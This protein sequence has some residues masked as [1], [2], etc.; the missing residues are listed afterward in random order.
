M[1]QRKLIRQLIVI[2]ATLAVPIIP[3]VI[4]GEMPGERWLSAVDDNSLLFGFSGSGLLMLDILLPIPSSIIGT[5]LGARLGLWSGF[6]FTWGGLLVGNFI[7]FSIARFASARFRSW[8]PPFPKSTTQAIVFLSR[9]VPVLAEAVAL[10]AGTTSMPLGRFLL[11]CAGGNAIY[12]GALCGNGATL[13][14]DSL[15]GPGLII[16][17]AIP[18]ITWLIWQAV[19]KR[20]GR[21]R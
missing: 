8:L 20:R 7:G 12:A 21:A 4:I 19:E 11:L 10:A 16:P 1:I 14:P 17:M 2:A 9:P 3:F 13:L 15:I 18:V 6:L 5:I